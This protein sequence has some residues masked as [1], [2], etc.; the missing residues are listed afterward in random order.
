MY[1]IIKNLKN[2]KNGLLFKVI[3]RRMFAVI[4]RLRPANL[5]DYRQCAPN[6][7]GFLSDVYKRGTRAKKFLAD[8]VQC[9]R[10][11]IEMLGVLAIIGVLSIGGIAGYG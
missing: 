3:R 11:M 4:N 7:T 8:G 1:K 6:A 9:G 5:K 10:S 2:C